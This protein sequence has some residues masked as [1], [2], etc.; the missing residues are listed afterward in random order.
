MIAWPPPAN[1]T[2]LHGFLGLIGYYRKFVRNYGIIARPLTNLLKKGKFGWPEEAEAAF[3]ALKQA[4]ITTPTLA[5]PNFS[6]SFT[7]ETD[8]SG[9]GIGAVLTQQGRPITFMSA[10][11]ELQR[12]L[13]QSMPRRCLRL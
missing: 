10:H 2:K 12:K 9:E 4:M 3:L 5:M 11:W 6:E 8:V 1:I 7:I 13:G